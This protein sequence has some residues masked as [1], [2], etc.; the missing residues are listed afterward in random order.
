MNLTAMNSHSNRHPS[1]KDRPGLDPQQLQQTEHP[2]HQRF[3]RRR[4]TTASSAGAIASI[5]PLLAAA[6]YPLLA[7]AQRCLD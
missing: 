5:Y 2:C 4:H 6:L 7:A 3:N 1:Q